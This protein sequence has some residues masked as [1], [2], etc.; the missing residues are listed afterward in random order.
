MCVRHGAASA[1]HASAGTRAC[2]PLITARCG[3]PAIIVGT[4]AASGPTNY[5]RSPGRQARRL[6]TARSAQCATMMDHCA[7]SG[8][9]NGPSSSGHHAALLITAR[10]V[11]HTIAPTCPDAG[12]RRSSAIAMV[13][14]VT[15]ANSLWLG[16]Q[17]PDVTDSRGAWD[18]WCRLA[19]ATTVGHRGVALDPRLTRGPGAR[20]SPVRIRVS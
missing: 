6:I 15:N 14:G 11:E 12:W 13:P 9:P 17:V 20:V 18:T 3:R 4:C 16:S 10:S 2:S 8:V 7:P 19:L 1:E 5:P